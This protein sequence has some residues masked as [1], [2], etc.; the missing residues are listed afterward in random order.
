MYD[1]ETVKKAIDS[2]NEL[3]KINVIGHRRANFIQKIYKCSINTVYNWIKKYKDFDFSNFNKP[4]YNNIKITD[5]IEK[6]ILS[7]ISKFNTFD[8]KEIKKTLKGNIMLI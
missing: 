3:E 6:F 1:L 7:S 4:K 2:F 8:V 5:E